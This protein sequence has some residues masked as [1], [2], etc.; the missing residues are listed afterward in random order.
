[1]HVVTYEIA[2]TGVKDD[3][4]ALRRRTDGDGTVVLPVLKVLHCNDRV[5]TLPQPILFSRCPQL[6][7]LQRRVGAMAEWDDHRGSGQGS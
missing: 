7:A 2:G 6:A 3:G 4:E 5:V 1:M